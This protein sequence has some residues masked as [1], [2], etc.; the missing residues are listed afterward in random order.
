MTINKYDIGDKVTITGTFTDANDSAV[1]PAAVRGHYKKPG[2]TTITY[3]YGTD[4]ELTKDA[5]GVYSFDISL[6]VAGTWYYR[7][8]DNDANVATEGY[9]RVRESNV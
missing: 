3:I 4:A 2:E 7:M 5:T 1:D 6:D 9:F 8:D